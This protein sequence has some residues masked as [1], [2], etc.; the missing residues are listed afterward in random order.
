MSE[1]EARINGHWIRIQKTVKRL[2][3]HLA[4]LEAYADERHWGLTDSATQHIGGGAADILQAL[5]DIATLEEMDEKDK[6]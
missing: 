3:G 2:K 4:L 6:P 1:S 5:A